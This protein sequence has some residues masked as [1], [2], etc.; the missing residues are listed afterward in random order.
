MP[1]LKRAVIDTNVWLSALYFS[2]KPAQVV[3]LVE[4]SKFISVTSSFI[5]GELEEKM[6]NTFDT[7]AFY[8]AGTVSYIKS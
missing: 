6:I 4:D 5:L 8:A 3:N 2:G 7:P 1:N